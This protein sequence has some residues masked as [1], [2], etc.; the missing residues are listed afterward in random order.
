MSQHS[1]AGAEGE[2]D[3]FGDTEGSHEECIGLQQAKMGQGQGMEQL[4]SFIHRLVLNTR[5][6]LGTKR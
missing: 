6:V 5:P 4:R 3:S 2:V 1:I